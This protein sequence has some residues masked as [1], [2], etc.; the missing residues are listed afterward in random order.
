M[1]IEGNAYE[2][3]TLKPQL[4]QVKELTGAKNRKAIV[5]KGCHVRGAI[6]G[7]NIVM[8]KNLRHESYYLKM[9]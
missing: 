7:L 5:D 1:A 8:P 3:H 9:S 6:G 4:D 2:G